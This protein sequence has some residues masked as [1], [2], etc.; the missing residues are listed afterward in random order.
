VRHAG[1]AGAIGAYAQ[2][3]Q[4]A[5]ELRRQ[6]FGFSYADK[7]IFKEGDSVKPLAKPKVSISVADLLP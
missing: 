1:D 7:M 5:E 3:R 2:D 6:H 4:A